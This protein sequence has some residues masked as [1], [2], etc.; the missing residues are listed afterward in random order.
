M[1]TLFV[2]LTKIQAIRNH[3]GAERLEIATVSNYDVI[4]GKGNF[5][6]GDAVIYVPVG[7]VLSEELEAILF[8]EG[9][10]VTLNNR[11]I[12]A[13]KIRGIISQGLLIDPAD[14]KI[15]AILQKQFIGQYFNS[16]GYIGKDVA[17]LLG[18]TKYQEPV[19]SLPGIMQTNPNANPYKVKEFKEYTDI[20]HGKYYDRVLQDGE[21]VVITQKLH[22]TSAR[23]GWFPRPAISLLD[24]SRKFLGLLPEWQFCWGSRRSQIQSKPGQSHPGF[25]SEAQ[26]VEF[27]DVYTKIAAQEKL[28][29]KIPKGYSVYGE[30]VGWGIQKGYLYNCGL[31]KHDFYVYDIMRDGKWL[32]ANEVSF[33]CKLFNLKQVPELYSGPYSKEKVDEKLT[34]NVISKEIAEGVVVT[35]AIERSSPSM[36]RVKLKFINPEYLV[37]KNNTEFQ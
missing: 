12:R 27:G 18:I 29:D 8:P 22:G 23:Y 32:N 34:I 15:H 26:G 36:G 31:N 20:E 3:D 14:D 5:E 25:K 24:K 13:A 30:I 19:K 4:I 1:S 16:G 37:L 9:S 7:S 21:M 11:R 10:K 33:Y 6:V 17:N 28:R 35:P 2:P